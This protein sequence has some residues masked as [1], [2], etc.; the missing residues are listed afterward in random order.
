V[1]KNYYPKPKTK[2]LARALDFSD[3]RKSL[4]LFLDDALYL[5]LFSFFYPLPIN[6]IFHIYFQDNF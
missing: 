5:L 6:S 2:E 1:V 4:F 3:G